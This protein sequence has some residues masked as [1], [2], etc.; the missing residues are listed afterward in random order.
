MIP[1]GIK[2]T[3]LIEYDLIFIFVTPFRYLN[4][5]IIIFV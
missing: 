3:Q 2:V 5:I 1:V 4:F